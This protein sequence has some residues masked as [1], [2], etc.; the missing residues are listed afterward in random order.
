MN[1]REVPK[2]ASVNSQKT[3]VDLQWN[4]KGESWS[5]T[6]SKNRSKRFRTE[7]KL[8]SEEKKDKARNKRKYPFN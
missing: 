2:K 4:D 5:H 7:H 3:A 1:F 8:A 6:T